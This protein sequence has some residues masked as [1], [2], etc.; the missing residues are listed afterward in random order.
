MSEVKLADDLRMDLH[1]QLEV[2]ESST[3]LE[4]TALVTKTGYG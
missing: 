1:R 2:L 3:D 4:G